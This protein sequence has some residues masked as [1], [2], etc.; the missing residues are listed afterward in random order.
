MQSATRFSELLNFLKAQNI[1]VSTCEPC[2]CGCECANALIPLSGD[3]SFR[4]YY[5][6]KLDESK[7]L[8]LC[9]RNQVKP[10][11][12]TYAGTVII[13]DAPVDTQKNP[14]FVRINRL[15]RSARVLVPAIICQDLEHGFMVLEDLGNTLF[16]DMAVEDERLAFYFKAMVEMMK[17]TCLPQNAA[18]EQK[19][20]TCRQ[21]AHQQHSNDE[22][23][24]PSY[25]AQQSAERYALIEQLPPFDADFIAMELG[26][27]TEWLLDKRLNLTLSA[28]EQSM[29]QR[30]FSFLSTELLKQ[31]QVP[32]HRDFH[33]RNLMVT[34]DGCDSSILARLAVIDYQDMVLGPL[35]Y[36][37][38]SLLFD[39]YTKLDPE[40]RER[41]MQFGYQ[42]CK[43]S[44]M[45][46]ES[47]SFADYQ[48]MIKICA[49][50]RHIKVLGIFN[51]L[52]LRDGKTGYLKDLPLVLEYVL[53]NCEVFPEM[54]DF[55]LFLL[56]HVASTLI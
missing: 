41:L 50:Q 29:L 38:A 25:P 40:D 1:T 36:D 32:M 43:A 47:V 7:F 35:G 5:R 19:L 18:Q 10:S 23:I 52:A 37:A 17:I 54:S 39:C 9:E 8:Q 24:I 11:L 2:D 4:R 30:T 21:T 56:K 45:F 31:P 16:F 20:N 33:C 15:L 55:K 48:R 13:M 26:I 6:L 27:F 34:P 49:L 53:E 51:R 44:L 46:D 3:A 14:E 28:D 22:F 12:N 42:V